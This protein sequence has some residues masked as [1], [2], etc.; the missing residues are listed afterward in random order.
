MR[1]IMKFATTP[2]LIL[3]GGRATRLGA[4][5]QA[6][7]K[8]LIPIA[9][10]PFIDYQ[11]DRLKSHGICDVVLCVGHFAEQ[12]HDHV[13]SGS[14]FGLR[15]WYSNDGPTPRGTGG[16]V[17]NALPLI[18]DGCW[19]LYGDSL[20]DANY[21]EIFEELPANALGLMTVYRNEDRY[22]SSNVVFRNG[23]LLKYCKTAKTPDMTHI[24]YGLS[25]LRAEAIARI[26]EDRPTDLAE[27]L[28]S[29]SIEGEL[30]GV[31]MHRRFYEIGSPSGLQEAEEFLRRV[32]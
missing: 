10:R 15:V 13:G 6:V 1:T 28:S 4:I 30:V 8:A 11:L 7:P 19:V 5:S 18:G 22:D 27:L 14:Q 29:L 25:L 31:E 12:I 21:S 2:V 3:A 20:L 9:G 24:D 17:R 26:P 32:A 16:A 23:R